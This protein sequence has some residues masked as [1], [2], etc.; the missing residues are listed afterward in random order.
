M[1]GS[2][3]PARGKPTAAALRLRRRQPAGVRDSVHSSQVMRTSRGF[4]PWEGP[5]MPRSSSSSISRPAR[6]KPTFSFRWSIDVEPSCRLL[7]G[8]VVAAEVDV[9]LR[10]RLP[11][12]LDALHVL[13]LP[14]LPH[15][16]PH[17]LDLV[18][19]DPRP[20]DPGRA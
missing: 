18:L 6:A 13:G 12:P 1:V 11:H 15:P 20:L 17:R 3:R 2:S 8:R 5:T 10:G 4:E 16:V 7:D 14:L 19:G 9:V